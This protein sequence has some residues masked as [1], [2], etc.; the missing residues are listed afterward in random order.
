MVKAI[1]WKKEDTAKRERAYREEEE[2]KEQDRRRAALEKARQLVE[3]PDPPERNPDGGT[4]GTTD[5]KTDPAP[6]VPEPI[7][8]ETPLDILEDLRSDLASGKREEFPPTTID[9]GGN[10]YFYVET[11]MAWSQAADFAEQHGGHLV[12]L[13]DKSHLNWITSQIPRNKTIWLGGGSVSR[14]AWGWIDGTDWSL[15]RT[16]SS[17]TG[18]VACL[19]DLGTVRSQPPGKLLPFFIQWHMDGTNPGTFEAQLERT[20]T[21]LNAPNTAWPPGTLSFESRRYLI[22]SRQISW[23]EAAK[24]AR[25]SEGH[26][27]VPSD[28]AE[29]NYLIQAVQSSLPSGVAAWIG[30]QHNGRSWAWMTG[31]PW[32]FAAWS[33][34]SPDGDPATD[35]ALRIVTGDNAGWDDASPADTSAGGALVIEWSQDLVNKGGTELPAAT[36]ELA[37]LRNIAITTVTN[38]HEKFKKE[39]SYNGSYVSNELDSW[40]R[41]KNES[42][43]AN[44]RDSFN[45]M[46][47]AIG[48]DGHIPS[49]VNEGNLPASVVRIVTAATDK[50]K[51]LELTLY[52]DVNKLRIAYLK[53]LKDTRTSLQQRGMINEVKAIDN[54]IAACGEDGRSF[55]EHFVPQP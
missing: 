11:P 3:K 2:R 49:E 15:A 51:R 16:P 30:G 8:V 27:A 19:T 44:Y 34:D 50:Q 41:S 54:E 14:S 17:S 32:T 43:K 46:K 1:E 4:N 33:P 29:S 47:S 21:T 25:L 26:L 7:P 36:G 18:S 48:T 6:P 9:R 37:R 52:D 55:L 10:R 5:P 24:L 28:Q 22:I 31:E 45:A 42:T 12:T 23:T 53:R 13:T 20:R 35:S 38:R 39:I 40:F